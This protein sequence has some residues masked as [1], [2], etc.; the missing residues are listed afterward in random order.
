[1]LHKLSTS[2]NF[3]VPLVC[4]VAQLSFFTCGPCQ[5]SHHC[6]GLLVKIGSSIVLTCAGFLPRGV[7]CTSVSKWLSGVLTL[8]SSPPLQSP[9]NVAKINECQPTSAT[10]HTSLDLILEPLKNLS[11]IVP[12][13]RYPFAK[14]LFLT[15]PAKG[16]RGCLIRRGANFSLATLLTLLVQ[17]LCDVHD[18]ILFRSS[19]DS[20]SICI[21]VLR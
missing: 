12:C 4:S 14:V 11:T 19:A 3:I 8:N 7:I 15:M 1:M 20:P 17:F 9:E 13:S 18:K 6:H 10:H 2:T 5:S 21:T 16:E